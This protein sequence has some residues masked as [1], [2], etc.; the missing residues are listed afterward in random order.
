MFRIV[1]K[2]DIVDPFSVE[3]FGFDFNFAKKLIIGLI[4][5]SDFTCGSIT[6]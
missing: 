3:T 6:S 2:A 5:W 4:N 1:I